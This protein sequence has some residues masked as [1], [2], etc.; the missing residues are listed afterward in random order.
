MSTTRRRIAA[1]LP[2]LAAL[3][4][5]PIALPVAS[6]SPPA[7]RGGEPAPPPVV[8]TSGHDAQAVDAPRPNIL[9]IFSDDHAVQAIGAYGSELMPTPHIDR[10]AA[11]GV[12]FRNSFCGNSLCGPSRA[13]ILTG[14]HSA[15]NG[16]LRNGNR[17]DG[18]QPTFPKALRAAGYRTALFGK[19]HLGTDPEGFD[20]W[21]VLPGQGQYYNPDFQDPDGE[22]RLEGHV[23][24]LTTG[25]ALDW[26]E[27]WWDGASTDGERDDASAARPDDSRAA[28]APPADDPTRPP[29]LL[30]VQHKAPHRSWMPAPSELGLLR[31]RDLP[32]PDTLFD[33][34]A[35]RAPPAAQQEMEIA[36]HLTLFYDLKLVP[37]SEE[38]P[39][40]EGPD[41]WVP[42]MRDRLTPDQL[43]AWDA[44]Y[45]EENA[46]FRADPPT[47]DDLVRWKYQRYLK[48][49]LRCVA[50]VD[51]SVGEL[52]AWLDARPEVAANTLVVYA[53]DQGFYLGEH[54]W[55]DKRWMYEESLRMPLLLRWPAGAPAGRVVEE[56]VQNI[57][58]A[59]T[60]LE[61]AG[62][63]M[64]R[65][66]HGRS[67]V[68]LLTGDAPDDDP[69][70]ALYYRYDESH[71][72]H[73]VAAHD[74]VRT[75]RYKLI[76]FHEPEHDTWELYDLE[77]DPRELTSVADEPHSADIRAALEL[78]LHELR[79]LYGSPEH[80]PEGVTGPW[81][82]PA[83]SSLPQ[84]DLAHETSRQ[85][86]VDR[87]DGQY[88]GHPTTVLLEDG[89]TILCVYP[90]GH[91]RGPIV[92][93]RSTDG[94]LTWS[95]RLPVPDNW[96]TSRETP[97][98]HRVVDA[99]GVR[100]LVVW[101][102]LHPARLAV[103]E[104]DGATWSPLETAGDW[105]GIVVMG[106]LV[107]TG[108]GRYRAWFH[109]D[110]RFL[111]GDGAA[112][113]FTVY[114]VESDDGG[115]TWSAPEAVVAHDTAHLCEP[116]VVRSPDGAR[117]AMLLRENSRTRNSFVCFSDDDGATWSAPRELPGALT[118]DRHVAR[119][120]PDGRLVI[121]FRDTGRASPTR[122]DWVAW[123]GRFEDLEAGRE[124]EYR[125]RLMDNR[126]RW[127]C[128]YPGL[129][130]LPDGTY[131]AVT[132]GHWE[133]GAEPYV[134]AVRF[135]LD[136]LDERRR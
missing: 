56:M 5:I 86:V 83:A 21:R 53:S 14:L 126:H 48:N 59:P 10:L 20:T 26:L 81:P 136:E 120:A 34:Y 47:G 78:R 18:A 124:G 108:A 3:L 130:V 7:A 9:F 28:S 27:E 73:N 133:E 127:D 104:D 30:M 109:D 61:L 24:D 6:A 2:A 55:Y 68:P 134:V 58:Y 94:G 67:L 129:E 35:G 118:G 19:W 88:L 17:F 40:L 114:G 31:D 36:R 95:E 90:K 132:Y 46:A 117:L 96:A 25:M 102:G 116:G 77:L 23:T 106:S 15:A 51:R 101:S 91:G 105:G 32:E 84:L 125:V 11:E 113:A 64:G 119:Y 38:L 44:A 103:S 69:R 85:V 97:T 79:A 93:K 110:G 135:R 71:V 80:P 121:S 87:E 33:D 39:T 112:G 16:F 111:E 63:E 22:V 45:A 74:G 4:T 43:A 70:D 57:D 1:A 115:L 100:R 107:E 99:D 50:G 128:A 52:L 42:G 41:S 13:T 98:I 62:A 65:P 75:D 66:V 49:Y 92:L 122:G 72:V 76:R 123:V 37:T 29:F 89:R 8:A 82:P 54:G 131:L 60:F 12:L